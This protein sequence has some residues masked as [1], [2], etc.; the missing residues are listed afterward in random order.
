MEDIF[1]PEEKDEVLKE[2]KNTNTEYF[3][4]PF[5]AIKTTINQRLTRV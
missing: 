5:K 4:S 1:T 2:C 3:F